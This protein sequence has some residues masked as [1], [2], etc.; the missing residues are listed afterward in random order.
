MKIK[1]N[2]VV[3]ITYTL[4]NDAGEILDSNVGREGLYYL[5]GHGNLV[6]GL[7]EELENKVAGDKFSVAVSAEKGYGVAD[8]RL[9]QTVPLTAFGTNK[10]E[11][12][13][14]F[15]AEGPQGQVVVTVV[16]ITGDQ[17]KIDGNHPL[18][19]NTLNFDIVVNEVREASAEEI[20]HG[21]VHGPGGHHH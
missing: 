7:E 19:G 5:H 21:H 20:S 3:A 8:P 15:H 1:K 4:K 9:V 17:V 10:V 14:Q 18:A 2:S 12:G 16:E 13:M 6:I 11:V